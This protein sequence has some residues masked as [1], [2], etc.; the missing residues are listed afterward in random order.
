E[1]TAAGPGPATQLAAVDATAGGS[2][3]PETEPSA[4]LNLDTGVQLPLTPAEAAASTDWHLCFRRALVSVNGELGGPGDV[5][6]ADL[7]ASETEAETLEEV[8]AR[9]QA[10]EAARFDGVDHAKLTDPAVPY[11]GDHIVTAFSDKW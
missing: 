8:M 11:R 5:R 9:T 3:A 2:G 6:A 4:C 1:V 7:D 10:S